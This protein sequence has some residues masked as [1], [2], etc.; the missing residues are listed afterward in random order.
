MPVLLVWDLQMKQSHKV[1]VV[2]GFTVR[3]MY[4]KHTMKLARS[5]Y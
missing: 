5:I 4:E 3:L 1:W 2:L